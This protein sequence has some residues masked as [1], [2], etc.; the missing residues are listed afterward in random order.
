MKSGVGLGD[1]GPAARRATGAIVL[2]VLLTP[3]VSA[4]Y[5][6]ASPVIQSESVS[7]ITSTDAT[8][9]AEIDPEGAEAGVFYQFQLLLDPGEAT[10]ELACPPSPP[11][12]YST[13]AGPSDPSALPLGWICGEC[14]I[15]P[16]AVPV[17]LD[18][19]SAGASL[20]PG[21]TY[22]FRVLA[23]DRKFSEDVAEW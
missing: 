18:L 11:P 21:R 16:S 20:E 19:A 17:S 3:G 6:S 13:C 4:A 8:L 2:A 10:N 22:Y 1:S 23:A 14:E 12:G 5:A 9:E 15:E 7:K